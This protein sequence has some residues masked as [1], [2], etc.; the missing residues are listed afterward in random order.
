MML[1]LYGVHC[2]VF[3]SCDCDETSIPLC[4]HQSVECRYGEAASRVI[5]CIYSICLSTF[6]CMLS[7]NRHGYIK[8]EIEQTIFFR[9]VSSSTHLSNSMLLYGTKE[10]KID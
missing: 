5:G 8:P 6:V 3:C 1:T 10:Y 9:H 2:I 4:R 7:P